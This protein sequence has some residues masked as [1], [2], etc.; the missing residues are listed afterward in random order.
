M[1]PD[2]LSHAE[3]LREI[4]ASVER[5]PP[6]PES[7]RTQLTANVA[8][9]LAGAA[10]LDEAVPLRAELQAARDAIER[11]ELRPGHTT[12]MGVTALADKFGARVA[13]LEAALRDAVEDAED[14]WDMDAPS[15]NPGIKHWVE[16]G[17]AALTP[18][19]P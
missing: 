12:A 14:R 4:A 5:L 10:A 17:R 1:T 15:T 9:C 7:W 3:R 16:Q 2:P 8:A 11:V 19:A 18:E 6:S 13:Q